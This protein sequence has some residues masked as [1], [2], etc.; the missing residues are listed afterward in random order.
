MSRSPFLAMAHGGIARHIPF[1][2]LISELEFELGPAP[3]SAPRP[4]SL[5]PSRYSIRDG[6][7]I[8]LVITSFQPRDTGLSSILY[9]TVWAFLISLLLV[10]SGCKGI[11][12]KHPATVP[13]CS[14]IE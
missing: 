6:T 8:I 4:P 13:D 10:L 1:N 5:R 14:P 12:S 2:Y 7:N 9:E 11:G 3:S